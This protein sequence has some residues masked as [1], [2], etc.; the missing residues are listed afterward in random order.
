M[1]ELSRTQLRN[2]A[3]A[4]FTVFV[5]SGLSVSSWA[6]RVP[7]IQV[8]LGINKA[9]I[10]LLLLAAGIAAIV[11]ISTSPAVMVRTGARR[12]ILLS[13]LIFGTGV[14]LIGLGSS[15]WHSVPV[16]AVGL[17]LFGFG[18]GCVDVMINVEAADI[19]Q[20]YGR[21]MLPLFHALFSAGMV[22]GASIGW[23][24]SAQGWHVGA[25]LVGVAIAIGVL[26][27]IVTRAVPVR[28]GSAPTTTGKLPV[29]ARMRAFAE[30]WK[31]PRTYALGVVM[32]GMS[33][34]EG[35]ATDWLALGVADDKGFGAASGAMTLTV[36]TFAMMITRIVGGPL[37]DRVGRVTVLRVCAVLAVAG[38]LMF[39][40]AQALVWIVVGAALWGVGVS[41]GFPL[42]MSAAADDPVKAAGR[43]SA[44]ATIGYI[45]FLTGPPLLGLVAE[46]IGLL[47]ALLILAALAVLSGLFSGAARPLKSDAP[48]ASDSPSPVTR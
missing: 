33:F 2:W 32:L 43:V 18:N 39:I 31:E 36:F 23:L 6:S 48:T 17:A 25:H 3:I 41:L 16:V 27:I 20:R 47:N 1:L 11:G 29:K 42:G 9:Q 22:A 35:G 13:M 4:I 10:G 24:A 12:G 40:F 7:S 38:M 14:A 15:V 8:D 45:A 46:R 28:E 44:A 21:T 30:P 19:E 5:C 37:V 34:A 26:A